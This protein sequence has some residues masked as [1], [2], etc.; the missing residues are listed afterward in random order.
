MVVCLSDK[1]S[2]PYS[3][4][5]PVEDNG[6][7]D[8]WD[9]EGGTEEETFH[10]IIEKMLQ[11]DMIVK[12]TL[13][14]KRHLQMGIKVFKRWNIFKRNGCEKQY[15]AKVKMD[16]SELI[17]KRQKG[18]ITEC[19]SCGTAF[20]WRWVKAETWSPV[21]MTWRKPLGRA[22][23]LLSNLQGTILNLITIVSFVSQA[24]VHWGEGGCESDWQTEVG[25]GH[26]DA[27]AAGETSQDYHCKDNIMTRMIVVK[28]MK[29]WPRLSWW[30]S[31]NYDQ[32]E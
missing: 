30:R 23:M 4:I 13:T 16:Q 1:V 7:F 18:N 24:C 31:W 2:F 27:D 26:K 21:S 20:Q 15:R 28:I 5:C 9:L 8:T 6:T 3:D 11:V 14:S 29:L 12:W 10:W 32:D 19:K 17:A 25:S 22:T